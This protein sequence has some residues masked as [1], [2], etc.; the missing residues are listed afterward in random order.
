MTFKKLHPTESELEIL[1]I[2]W[3]K[4]PASVR[5]VNEL[6]NEHREVGYTTTLK[7]MQIMTEKSLVTR[8]TKTRTHIYHAAAQEGET[9]NN[10]LDKF[11]HKTYKGCVKSLVLQALGKEKASKEELAE[12]KALIENLE[13]NQD[14]SN[15]T[16]HDA[17]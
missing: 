3:D 7:I 2:L 5:A 8:D 15:P 17:D 6:L 14:T 16:T 9:Q 1:Q 10:L 11:L 13:N 4:G 12:L